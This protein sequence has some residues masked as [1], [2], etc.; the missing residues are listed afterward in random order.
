MS[1]KKSPTGGIKRPRDL[2]VD[3]N[4]RYLRGRT[5]S[6]PERKLRDI[7]ADGWKSIFEYLSTA[8]HAATIATCHLLSKA[9]SQTWG[10]RT[11]KQRFRSDLTARDFNTLLSRMN[12][13]LAHELDFSR[14]RLLEYSLFRQLGHLPKL[15]TLAFPTYGPEEPKPEDF[16]FLQGLT[17]LRCLS[18]DG[19]PPDCVTASGLPAELREV[20]QF[21]L[22]FML[23]N[24]NQ[25]RLTRFT[26]RRTD[27]YGLPRMNAADLAEQLEKKKP[28]DAWIFTKHDLDSITDRRWL[29]VEELPGFH[30]V[31]IQIRHHHLP[32]EDMREV[33]WP[34]FQETIEKSCD[35]LQALDL[36]DTMVDQNF[37]SWL[38]DADV[39]EVFPLKVLILQDLTMCD[40][41]DTP[42]HFWNRLLR[43]LRRHCPHLRRLC[44]TGVNLHE[45][46]VASIV[47]QMTELRS[48]ELAEC[49]VGMECLRS[50]VALPVLVH[51]SFGDIFTEETMDVWLPILEQM[52]SLKQVDLDESATS[53]TQEAI[54]A[55]SIKVEILD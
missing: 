14:C 1:E 39:D 3:Y 24:A 35:K 22:E 42:E 27:F 7:F 6:G 5:S 26:N 45:A 36:F 33:D 49:N 53:K 21:G 30:Y 40:L 28:S 19:I 44:I 25:K 31:S 43:Q 10:R 51:L 46:T 47:C 2:I 23:G 52:R 48:L 17:G 54:R 11:L 41:D 34:L 12:P 55:L 38:L 50:L 37:F 8:D 20:S 16:E 9:G 4:P 18:V 13:G 29:D 32:V 15:H